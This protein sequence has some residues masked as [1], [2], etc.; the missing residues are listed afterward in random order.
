MVICS[1]SLCVSVTGLLTAYRLQAI[2]HVS[3]LF[4]FKSFNCSP[5][6]SFKTHS[7]VCDCF[8][9]VLKTGEFQ[10]KSNRRT[11]C[12]FKVVQLKWLTLTL[13]LWLNWFCIAVAR[14]TQFWNTFEKVFVCVCFFFIAFSLNY[15]VNASLII[16]SEGGVRSC[17]CKP[18]CIPN[19]KC[20]EL[21]IGL[22]WPN[23]NST[24]NKSIGFYLSNLKMFSKVNTPTNK[25]RKVSQ[26]AN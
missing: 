12:W 18:W 25:L 6:R 9:S 17:V 2:F 1:H 15:K 13:Q 7:S 14:V 11:I 4:V 5:A 19:T 23:W 20:H 21:C 8:E 24:T 10:L 26:I 3:V 16:L 22:N